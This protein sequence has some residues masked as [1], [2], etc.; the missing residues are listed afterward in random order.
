MCFPIT[1]RTAV[2]WVQN[3]MDSCVNGGLVLA[4]DLASGM[5]SLVIGMLIISI[6]LGPRNRHFLP[7]GYSPN[8]E[9]SP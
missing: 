9:D 6:V 4:G 1:S 3:W 8:R 7:S 5:N 2:M